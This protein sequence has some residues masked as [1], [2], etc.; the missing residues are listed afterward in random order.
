MEEKNL[1]F[2]QSSKKYIKKV[3]HIRDRTDADAWIR[4]SVAHSHQSQPDKEYHA[5]QDDYRQSFLIR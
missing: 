5:G 1:K 4:G 3:G 2:Y